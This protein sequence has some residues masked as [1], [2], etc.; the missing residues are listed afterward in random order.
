MDGTSAPSASHLRA[1]GQGLAADEPA[2][3]L[4][5]RL[6]RRL[7]RLASSGDGGFLQQCAKSRLER[8]QRRL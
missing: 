4:P 1:P 6:F 2:S 7:G 5:F 3:A 8:N